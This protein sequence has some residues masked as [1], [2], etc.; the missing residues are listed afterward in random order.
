MTLSLP[1]PDAY[2]SIQLAQYSF[3]STLSPAGSTW[4]GF[5]PSS[6]TAHSSVN[7]FLP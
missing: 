5:S 1:Q 2:F 6:I 7:A 3:H 4:I